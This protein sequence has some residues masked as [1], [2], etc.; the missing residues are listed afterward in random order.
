MNYVDVMEVKEFN[1][2]LSHSTMFRA[3]KGH[4]RLMFTTDGIRRDIFYYVLE[5]KIFAV[6]LSCL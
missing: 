3:N 1:G 4:F 6:L 5:K 2:L